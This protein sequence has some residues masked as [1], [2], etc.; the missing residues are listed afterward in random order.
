M[1][2]F[3]TNVVLVFCLY[4]PDATKILWPEVI[5]SNA[6]HLFVLTVSQLCNSI[7]AA[8]CLWY[9][10]WCALFL[11]SKSLQLFLSLK[12][13]YWFKP[14][15]I[16]QFLRWKI[17]LTG[18]KISTKCPCYTKRIGCFLIYSKLVT[19]WEKRGYCICYVDI[20]G[21]MSISEQLRTYLSPNPKL[22]LTCYHL[23]AVGLGE[24]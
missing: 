8:L 24:G 12:S 6:P 23:T 20:F 3:C 18:T 14:A 7:V 1:Y 4:W 2:I 10:R 17:S 16:E 19:F 13:P 22:T 15:Y 9:T 5:V 11:I 21:S